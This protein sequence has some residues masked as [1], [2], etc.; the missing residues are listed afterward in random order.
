MWAIRLL[1]RVAGV[2]EL[3]IP[4]GTQ[5]CKHLQWRY[6]GYA[7]Q[8]CFFRDGAITNYS[9]SIQ[10]EL[11]LGVSGVDMFLGGVR[12]SHGF[13]VLL[14]STLQ[15]S[16]TNVDSANSNKYTR[17][18]KVTCKDKNVL[19]ANNSENIII[20]TCTNVN[21]SEWY[22]SE[23]SINVSCKNKYLSGSYH[24]GKIIFLT[25]ISGTSKS[26][27]SFEVTARG[28]IM[29]VYFYIGNSLGLAINC[30]FNFYHQAKVSI[31]SRKEIKSISP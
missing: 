18:I 28:L 2:C 1:I 4:Q 12:N 10:I 7:G 31:L 16:L 9:Y 3:F 25:Y 8:A 24:S 29:T 15:R 22:K 23:R 27:R 5:I 17:S 11:R 14:L 6:A 13:S 21:M 26:E 20:L 19:G 30:E